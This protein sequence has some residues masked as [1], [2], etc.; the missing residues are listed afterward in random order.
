M[1]SHKH[2]NQRNS[3]VD[4]QLLQEDLDHICSW[5]NKWQLHLNVSKCE[6]VENSDDD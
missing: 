5:A 4:C 6:A 1:H 3:E 2:T